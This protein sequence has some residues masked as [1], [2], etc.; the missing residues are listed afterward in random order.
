VAGAFVL[1]PRTPPGGGPAGDETRTT[2]SDFELRIV[3]RRPDGRTEA[4]APGGAAHPGDRL[5]FEVTVPE[6]AHV[7]VISLDAA[8]A[9]TPFGPTTGAGLAVPATRRTL[10]EGA[11]VLDDALGPERIVLVACKTATPLPALLDAARA[12]LARAGRDIVRTG[13]EV[14]G[15][16]GR[17]CR[18]RSAWVRRRPRG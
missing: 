13:A 12:A 7:A 17:G 2:G 9:V 16:L 8:G 10:L 3:A 18:E 5:R 15:A 4:L 14:V 1:A 11:V 6:A